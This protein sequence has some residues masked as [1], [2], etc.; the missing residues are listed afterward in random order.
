WTPGHVGI[1]GNEKADEEA[2]AAAQGTS[3]PAST[4]PKLLRKPLPWSKSAVRKTYK[5]EA[6][7]IREKRERQSKHVRRIRQLDPKFTPSHFRKLA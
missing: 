4:L 7:A 5:K 1:E 2:K 6:K 3:S